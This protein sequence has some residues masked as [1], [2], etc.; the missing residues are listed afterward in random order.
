MGSPFIQIAPGSRAGG[1][2]QD[3][4]GKQHGIRHKPPKP[5]QKTPE[6]C[7]V[8]QMSGSIAQT[9]PDTERGGRQD[10][11]RK[12]HPR[13]VRRKKKGSAKACRVKKPRPEN[14]ERQKFKTTPQSPA[15][16]QK[17]YRVQPR[18]DTVPKYAL[19][20][21]SQQVI[22]PGR[23]WLK[24]LAAPSELSSGTRLPNSTSRRTFRESFVD[25]FREHF[26]AFSK[27]TLSLVQLTLNPRR[28]N[29][30][31][32]SGYFISKRKKIR[33]WIFITRVRIEKQ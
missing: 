7:P 13:P 1:E 28:K 17:K 22:C 12:N 11:I 18:S 6:T 9:S 10:D 3:E 26:F 32:I 33:I 16:R 14:S 19:F 24:D 29:P 2:R 23:S 25:Y 21:L 8:P 20:H 27:I 4:E 31:L 30:A 5:R 15:K